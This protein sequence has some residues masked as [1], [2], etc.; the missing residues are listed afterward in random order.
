MVP[1]VPGTTG[2]EGAKRRGIAV[3]GVFA[4]AGG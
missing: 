4:G 2:D 3:P 1:G